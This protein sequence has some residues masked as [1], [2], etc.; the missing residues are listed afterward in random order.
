MIVGVTPVSKIYCLSGIEYANPG[1]SRFV[2]N[3]VSL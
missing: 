2:Q 3:L 1:A